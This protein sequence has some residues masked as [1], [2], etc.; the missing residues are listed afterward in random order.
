VNE[1]ALLR[2]AAD[3]LRAVANILRDM[4]GSPLRHAVPLASNS[5]TWQGSFAEGL[6]ADLRHQ[7]ARLQQVADALASAANRLEILAAE[8]AAAAAMGPMLP[9]T[10]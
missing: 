10:E 3:E 1:P 5:S 4:W 9:A 8:R 6:T 2:E 7:D